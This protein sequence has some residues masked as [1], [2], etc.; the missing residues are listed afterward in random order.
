MMTATSTEQRTESSCAFLKRPPLRFRNVLTSGVSNASCHEQKIVGLA[1]PEQG[2]QA[3]R[4]FVHTTIPPMVEQ[5][6]MAAMG[7][8]LHG[9][10]PVILDR[11]DLNLPSAH[12]SDSTGPDECGCG[13]RC[14]AGGVVTKMRTGPRCDSMAI[15]NGDNCD[16]LSRSMKSGRR[17]IY[18]ISK[19]HHHAFLQ[20]S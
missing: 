5:M 14:R 6:S 13:T 4:T 11:L 2:R 1:Q 12:D 3:I 19:P 17:P 8:D 9:A 16:R 20:H 7:D 10:V 15:T 18:I